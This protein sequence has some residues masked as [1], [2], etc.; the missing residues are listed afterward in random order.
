MRERAE[1]VGG[2]LHVSRSAGDANLGTARPI[3]SVEKEGTLQESEG[4]QRG[5]TVTA[6]LPLP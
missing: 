6:R 1:G 4:R 5:A 3:K 2:T